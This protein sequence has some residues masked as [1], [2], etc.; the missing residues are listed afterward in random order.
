MAPV[1]SRLKTSSPFRRNHNFTLQHAGR[2]HHHA[3]AERGFA[4]SVKIG[5][6]Y[7]FGNFTGE[8][9]VVFKTKF[10]PDRPGGELNVSRHIPA[11]AEDRFGGA[12]GRCGDSKKQRQQNFHDFYSFLF[13]RAATATA[14][15]LPTG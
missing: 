15:T 6:P 5:Q 2:L 3:A 9:A 4:V 13:F 1:T 10:Q 7:Q 12:G 14:L 8:R 11:T